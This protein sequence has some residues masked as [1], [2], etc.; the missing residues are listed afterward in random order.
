[1]L[2]TNYSNIS[3]NH[4]CKEHTECSY[5]SEFNDQKSCVLENKS[6][7]NCEYNVAILDDN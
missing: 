3:V 1:M 4:A 7:F 5:L 6:N 2:T